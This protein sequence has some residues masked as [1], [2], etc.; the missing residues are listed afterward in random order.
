M[1]NV[2]M[3]AVDTLHVSSAGPNMIQRDEKFQV[4]EAEA[5]ELEARGL[6]KRVGAAK[7][8]PA[9]A[10]KMADAPDNKGVI[11]AKTLSISAKKAK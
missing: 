10:N 6:A 8:E 1:T 3:K 2:T 4:N 7:A 5:K 9:P 11:S